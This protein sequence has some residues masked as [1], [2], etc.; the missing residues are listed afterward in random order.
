MPVPEPAGEE[1]EE[2]LQQTT[3]RG[4][5]RVLMEFRK[6]NSVKVPE[7]LYLDVSLRLLLLQPYNKYET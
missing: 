6:R 3:Y 2:A 4:K 1:E 5:G 7:V